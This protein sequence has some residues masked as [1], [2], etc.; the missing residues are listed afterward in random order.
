[1]SNLP[2]HK[3]VKDPSFKPLM[4][5]LG[6]EILIYTPLVAIYFL[7][8]LPLLKD[9][10]FDLYHETPILYAALGTFVIAAQGIS[11]EFL[12]SWI[13]RRIGLRH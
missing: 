13:L 6:L 3:G 10:F 5:S 1:M 8:A 9:V 12:T 2:N 7:I 11:L 4:R